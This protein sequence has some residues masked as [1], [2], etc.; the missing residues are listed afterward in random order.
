MVLKSFFLC[1]VLMLNGIALAQ[2]QDREWKDFK[3]QPEP[4]KPQTSHDRTAIPSNPYQFQSYQSI[5]SEVNGQVKNCV[6]NNNGYVV[7]C[8]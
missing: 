1:F 2:S 5:R 3:V 6:I 4:K 7:R 8:N